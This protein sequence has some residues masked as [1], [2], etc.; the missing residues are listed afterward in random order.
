MT[1]LLLCVPDEALCAQTTCSSDASFLSEDDDLLL[2]FF[3]KNSPGVSVDVTRGV[4]HL[5]RRTCEVGRV[6]GEEHHPQDHDPTP[7]FEAAVSYTGEEQREA[8]FGTRHFAVIAQKYSMSLK[9]L[10]ACLSVCEGKLSGDVKYFVGVH[11]TH[12]LQFEAKSVVLAD[13]LITILSGFE[14][15]EDLLTVF[16]LCQARNDTIPRRAWADV[17]SDMSF[18]KPVDRP[19]SPLGSVATVNIPFLRVSDFTELPL[20]VYCL[21]RLDASV[22]GLRHMMCAHK[23]NCQCHFSSKCRVC[24]SWRAANSMQ[25]SMKKSNAD[26]YLQIRYSLFEDDALEQNKQLPIPS[27]A[28]WGLDVAEKSEKIEKIEKIEE[29][30][31]LQATTTSSSSSSDDTNSPSDVA[32]VSSKKSV[33][34]FTLPECQVCGRKDTLW[35]CMMCGFIGCGRYSGQHTLKHC[36]TTGHAIVMELASQKIWDY[37]GDLFIHR[38]IIHTDSDTVFAGAPN[39]DVLPD[40]CIEETKQNVDGKSIVDAKLETKHE[41][42]CLEFSHLLAQQLESGRR[43]HAERRAAVNEEITSLENEVNSLEPTAQRKL[44]AKTVALAERT[45]EMDKAAATL[46]DLE[47]KNVELSEKEVRLNAELLVARKERK[48]LDADSERV[49]QSLETSMRAAFTQGSEVDEEIADLKAQ[50]RDM[51][52]ALEMR[53]RCKHVDTSQS[54]TFLGEAPQGGRKRKSKR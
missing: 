49:K 29:R 50:I 32:L 24:T 33:P 23:E 14:T 12:V 47:A 18:S 26:L 10:L 35:A 42:V 28:S 5:Y 1:Y 3:P 44:D 27:D 25:K 48:V 15:A 51:E 21:E 46:E 13:N 54:V 53:E 30:E 6:T 41:L 40:Q 20:C 17:E 11:H 2:S 19:P 37:D 8:S 34:P 39:K 4:L 36:F 38:L 7:R 16:P 45:A 52:A 22:S 31:I 9:R 43:Y